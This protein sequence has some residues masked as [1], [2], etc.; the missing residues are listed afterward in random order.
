MDD[1][2]SDFDLHIQWLEL[3]DKRIMDSQKELPRYPLL[4]LNFLQPVQLLEV[5]YSLPE[6]LTIDDLTTSMPYAILVN[7]F[8]PFESQPEKQNEYFD[9]ILSTLEDLEVEI[10]SEINANTLKQKDIKTHSDFCLILEE[11]VISKSIPLQVITNDI[12][13]LPRSFYILQHHPRDLDQAISIWLSKFPTSQIIPEITNFENDIMSGQHAAFCLARCFPNKIPKSQVEVGPMLPEESSKVNWDLIKNAADEITL[14]ILNHRPHTRTLFRIFVADVFHATRNDVRNFSQ[15]PLD[16][17]PINEPEQIEMPQQIPTSTQNPQMISREAPQPVQNQPNSQQFQ[18]PIPPPQ[19]NYIPPMNPNP[20]PQMPPYGGNYSQSYPHRH[21][22]RH[23]RRNDYSSY[24]EYSSA[25]PKH[26]KRNSTTREIYKEKIIY[27]PM[28]QQTQIITKSRDSDNDFARFTEEA[29]RFANSARDLAAILNSMKNDSQQQR[30]QTQQPSYQYPTYL[31]PLFTYYFNPQQKT[32]KEEDNFDGKITDEDISKIQD[33]LQEFLGLPLSRQTKNRL[34]ECLLS[35]YDDPRRADFIATLL[36]DTL[37]GLQQDSDN[38]FK[39]LIAASDNLFRGNN[40]LR[41]TAAGE[42]SNYL[43]IADS[44]TPESDYLYSYSSSDSS[45]S[46][47]D[48]EIQKVELSDRNV[49]A[50][51][52]CSDQITQ[53]DALPLSKTGTNELFNK[54]DNSSIPERGTISV[55]NI[56]FEPTYDDVMREKLSAHISNFKEFSKMLEEVFLPGEN[57]KKMR[58]SILSDV[59]RISTDRAL[60]LITSDM[61]RYK[62][63]YYLSNDSG[64]VCKQS[65]KGPELIHLEDI[66]KSFNY[67]IGSQTFNKTSIDS[68]DAF[69]LRKFLE[70]QVW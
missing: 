28:P 34:K 53:S 5:D 63:A 26:H 43:E 52:S 58:R 62:G 10:P 17:I 20:M 25:E 48:K 12:L 68:C 4:S 22:S 16:N 49:E 56:K 46:T 30:T 31:Y 69:C 64:C 21:H 66:A 15:P 50:I 19:K 18:N 8:K 7:A 29:T 60:M 38:N 1:D 47:K 2:E 55:R 27:Q 44:S 32:N 54:I 67:E 45:V 70:P 24:G 35:R 37:Q 11:Y 14:F 41:D 6:S 33:A 51:I 3:M 59:C 36:D 42:S 23:R 40:H 61:K 9:I 65:G 13:K 57:F 39:N